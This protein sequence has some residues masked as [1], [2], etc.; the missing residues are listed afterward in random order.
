MARR[1]PFILW[2]LLTSLVLPALTWAQDQPPPYESAAKQAILLDGRS[3]KVLYEKGADDL[4]APASM[5]K[6]MTMVMVFEALKAGNLTMDQEILISK[7]AWRNGGAQSGGST[8][9]AE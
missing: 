9:Y 4:I 2:M 8:M 5:S 6:L 7:N 1:F 3:G